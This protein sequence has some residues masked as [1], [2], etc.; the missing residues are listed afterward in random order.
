MLH[1]GSAGVLPEARKVHKQR[2]L[3]GAV[4]VWEGALEEALEALEA[5]KALG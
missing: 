3:D 4:V 5:L 1:Q 2:N